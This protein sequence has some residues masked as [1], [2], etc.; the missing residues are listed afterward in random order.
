MNIVNKTQTLEEIT[1]EKAAFYLTLSRGNGVRRKPLDSSHVRSFVEKIERGLFQTLPDGVAFHQESWLA[2]GHHR[3]NAIVRSGRPVFMW[4]A[5]GLNDDDILALD[6]GKKRTMSDLT[7]LNRKI[8]D[9]INY[10]ARILDP[11]GKRLISAKDVLNS[12]E[13]PFAK[14]LMELHSQCNDHPRVY[15]A[16]PVRCAAVFWALNG[17]ED[18]SFQQYKALNRMEFNNF[19]P[20]SSL[21]AR[22]VS[23][24]QIGGKNSDELFAISMRVFDSSKSNYKKL[25]STS[26]DA[27]SEFRKLGHLIFQT[28]KK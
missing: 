10:A 21:F 19:S 22:R 5:R 8:T 1:P 15:S 12:L 3:L 23:L 24:S 25:Y 6:Q 16:A 14:K 27:R 7:G 13:L 11:A 2:N 28:F 9:C 26:E 18:Y 4:V 17:C 20:I